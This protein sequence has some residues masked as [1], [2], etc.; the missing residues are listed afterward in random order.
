MVSFSPRIFVTYSK[1]FLSADNFNSRFPKS[2]IQTQTY[3]FFRNEFLW[4]VIGVSAFFVVTELIPRVTPLLFEGV[5]R[6][7]KY[8]ESS[9]SLFAEQCPVINYLF[10][11]KAVFCHSLFIFILR[12]VRKKSSMRFYKCRNRYSTFL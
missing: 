10:L 6:G 9:P 5:G 4:I 11:T 12:F 2:C 8:V 1:A 3:I 7:Y